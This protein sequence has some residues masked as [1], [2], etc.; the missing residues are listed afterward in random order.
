[1]VYSLWGHKESNITE[2]LTLSLS[3]GHD[4]GKSLLMKPAPR[5]WDLD[6]NYPHRF[7]DG[8]TGGSWW[9]LRGSLGSVFPF[10]Y[11]L[12]YPGS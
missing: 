4:D 3:V 8:L 6:A 1:M 12:D 7:P 11:L 9:V 10:I 2:R 5:F